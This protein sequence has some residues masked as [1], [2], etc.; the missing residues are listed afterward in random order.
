MTQAMYNP[1]MAYIRESRQAFE[2]ALRGMQ[3]LEFVIANE[4]PPPQGNDI[5]IINKQN[6]RKGTRGEDQITV[7]ATYY[8]VGETIY[9]AHSL[10]N[11][12]QCK[13]VSRLSYSAPY[14]SDTVSAVDDKQLQQA[15]QLSL[16]PPPVYASSR[17]YIFIWQ[18]D[19]THVCF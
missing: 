15:L 6:R 13:L 9:K 10:G 8:V 14:I 2:G 18:P 4:A 17:T 1:S 12:L 7:I 3:G 19:A 11:I 16:Y 5:W